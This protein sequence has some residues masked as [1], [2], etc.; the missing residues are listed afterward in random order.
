MKNFL[1]I[2]Y[3]NAEYS[4]NKTMCYEMRA[5]SWESLCQNSTVHPI[6]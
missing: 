6:K 2:K 5:E 4:Q 3:V 1:K